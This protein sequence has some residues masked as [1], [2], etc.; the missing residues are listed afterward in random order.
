MF[1]LLRNKVEAPT[2]KRGLTLTSAMLMFYGIAFLLH[3]IEALAPDTLSMVKYAVLA[4]AIILSFRAMAERRVLR[5]TQESYVSMLNKS[6]ISFRWLTMAACVW[7]LSGA[8][9]YVVFLRGSLRPGE[10]AITFGLSF[11]LFVLAA[12]YANA[13][14]NWTHDSH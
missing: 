1:S 13:A 2:Y 8:V 9:A 4:I 3:T 7:S 5:E 6:V 11:A 10:H 14:K 12:A